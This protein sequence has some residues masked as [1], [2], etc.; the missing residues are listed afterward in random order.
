MSVMS[1]KD[2]DIDFDHY[3]LYDEL[4]KTLNKLAEKYPDLANLYSIGK[5]P[6]G[7]D[8]WVMELTNTKTGAPDKKPGFFIDGNCHSGEVTGSMV[9]LR[10]IH[11]L[12]TMYDEDSSVRDLLDTRI[13][14]ILPRLDPDGAEMFLTTPYH[15]TGG[16]RFY[17]LSEEEWKKKEGLYEEDIDG[18]GLIVQMRIKD[19]NGD[20]KVSEKDPRLMIKREKDDNRGTYYR[21]YREGMI[22]NY[23]GKEI[24]TAPSKHGLNLNRNYPG[25]FA[26]HPIQSGAGPLPYSEPEIAAAVGF[27][28]K[29]L[30]ICGKIAYHT[31]GGILVRPLVGKSDAHILPRDLALFKLLG[32]IGQELTGYP[33]VGSYEGLTRDKTRARHGTNMDMCYESIYGVIHFCFELWDVNGKAG[34]GNYVERGGVEFDSVKEENALKLMK[35]NDE[36]LEGEGFMNWQPFDHP[37]LGPV[38]IGGWKSKFVTR[39]PPEKFL[40]EECD[41]AMKFSLKLASMTPL[42]KISKIKTEKIS[43]DIYRVRVTVENTGALPTNIIEHAVRNLKVA[44]PVYAEIDLGED[45]ELLTGREQI[46]LGHLEGTVNRLPELRPGAFAGEERSR[47]TAEWLIKTGREGAKIRV[48]AVSEKGGFDKQEIMLRD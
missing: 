36:N 24:K 18:N 42:I 41:K 19:P 31:S 15:R 26:P 1:P 40:R 3:Y 4:T 8:L 25:N 29:H 2:L 35:W 46:D 23:D 47:K 44:K 39:N 9:S 11:Y 38:E 33:S 10:T 34:L 12:L 21:L 43:E 16:G 45:A 7:R 14:Y 6:Q 20:W 22:L 30:N 37:Q 5:S 48:S 27:R 13:I 28:Q 17:P 32:E